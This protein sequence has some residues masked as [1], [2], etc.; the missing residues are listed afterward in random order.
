MHAIEGSSG[1]TVIS[2]TGAATIEPSPALEAKR[3]TRSF[4]DEEKPHEEIH[5]RA[6]RT[7]LW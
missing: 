1:L 3:T 4:A 7:I 6:E 5:E 2:P